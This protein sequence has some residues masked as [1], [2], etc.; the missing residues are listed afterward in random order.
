[1]NQI[2][3]ILALL[4]PDDRAEGNAFGKHEDEQERK[5]Y[6]TMMAQD[7]AI[8]QEAVR[9]SDPNE[10]VLNMPPKQYLKGGQR[11]TL[12]FQGVCTHC[13]HCG[14]PLS[15]SISIERGI[16]PVCSKKG[17]MED[18]V[19]SDEMQ[20]MIDLAEYPELVEFLT[21]KYKPLGVRGLM[22]GLVKICSLNRRSPVHQACC[23]AVESLGFKSLASLLRE[24]IAVIEVKDF[25]KDSFHVWVKKSE[26]SWG[27]TNALR[28]VPGTYFSRQAKGTIVPKTQKRALWD[29]M[30]K[31]YSGFCA[32]VPGSD[33]TGTKT[34]KI[35]QKTMAAP[36]ATPVP[37][38][39]GAPPSP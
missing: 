8:A 22:N 5:A 27:W 9:E 28:A 2:D 30:L 19:A 6:E 23:D 4:Q 10:L 34:V 3:Q 29:L 25:D 11:Y 35:Q 14:Q 15:D 21:A 20:A 33:G 37:P 24:S 18:P 36:P 39:P 31:H 32:K 26:W 17:Y 38:P 13:A 7:E 16:G 1:M 12:M